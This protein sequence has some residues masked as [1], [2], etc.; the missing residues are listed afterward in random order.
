MKAVELRP[1]DRGMDRD[2]GTDRAEH[3]AAV[4]SD[5]DTADKDTGTAARPVAADKDTAARPA[6]A[7]RVVAQAA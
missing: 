4:H 2:R 1:A 3:P 6:A 7:G 5:R